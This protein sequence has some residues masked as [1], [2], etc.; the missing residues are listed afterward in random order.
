MSLSSIPSE[1]ILEIVGYLDV[2]SVICLC[3]TSTTFRMLSKTSRMFWIPSIIRSELILPFANHQSLSS[4]DPLKLHFATHQAALR[5]RNILSLK[6]RILSYKRITWPFPV[7]KPDSVDQ[8]AG[9]Y[10][11]RSGS[12]LDEINSYY[13]HPS[14]TW[15][16]LLSTEN[17]FRVLHLETGHIVWANA[18]YRHPPGFSLVTERSVEVFA[19]DF[20]TDSR[21]ILALVFVVQAAA[22]PTGE[23]TWHRKYKIMQL[24]LAP[25][26]ISVESTDIT[27]DF[28]PFEV[29][30]VELCGPYIFFLER[31]KTWDSNGPIMSHKL[32]MIDW[33][34]GRKLDLPSSLLPARKIGAYPTYLISIGITPENTKKLQVLQ[35]AAKADDFHDARD[36]FHH[37]DDKSDWTPCLVA[38]VDFPP[39][40]MRDSSSE[41][42]LCHHYTGNPK[43]TVRICIR[44]RGLAVDSGW[45]SS[46][47]TFTVDLFRSSSEEYSLATSCEIAHRLVWEHEGLS[48]FYEVFGAGKYF[49]WWRFDHDSK[50]EE[51]QHPIRLFTTTIDDI[52]P[53]IYPDSSIDLDP[54]TVGV[55]YPSRELES[56]IKSKG[57]QDPHV[58][59]GHVVASGDV[60]STSAVAIVTMTYGDIWVLRYGHT[61]VF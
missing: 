2:Q 19:M 5:E 43:G 9:E 54:E 3:Q 4:C 55:N 6:P 53:I 59:N 39:S 58:P 30:T 22:T 47:F 16:F 49:V 61:G 25:L 34:D 18:Q 56:P 46:N 11:L 21:V 38:N 14:G 29:E 40:P 20:I 41:I 60:Q 28:L 15:M 48:H 42:K 8:D 1:L 32:H 44:N 36:L 57:A 26:S 10:I 7:T 33:R 17:I 12:P 45:S 27:Q 13:V 35:Y 31:N 51:D 24:D 52:E 50:D 23:I 37:S